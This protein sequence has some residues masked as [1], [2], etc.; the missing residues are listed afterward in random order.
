MAGPNNLSTDNG[1]TL[2]HLAL[3]ESTRD[4]TV[5][6]DTASQDQ[7][8][9]NAVAE[10]QPAP[11]T[12]PPRDWI[13]YLPPEIRQ[14]VFEYLLQLPYALPYHLP[15]LWRNRNIQARTGIFHTSRLIYRE[16][17]Y[18]FYSKNTFMVPQFPKVPTQQIGHMIQNI[19][20]DLT[21]SSETRA[22]RYRPREQF[23]ALMQ[24]FGD[25][26]IIRRTLN[27]LIYLSPQDDTLRPDTHLMPFFLRALGRFT[28]F[29]V[30]NLRL[31]YNNHNETTDLQSMMETQY[32]RVENALRLVLGPA[33]LPRA[34][35][36]DH[37]IFQPRDF[38]NAQQRS[39]RRNGD[40]MHHLD[41]IRLEWNRDR[42][43]R[44]AD[45]S[46]SPV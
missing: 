5:L 33:R 20:V 32:E 18:V 16:S 23:L 27:L 41:G 10:D 30:L 13:L 2:E 11:T 35:G 46:E 42:I 9:S 7:P 34:T 4:P 40:W 17:I 15:T 28:N 3:E 37:L 14:M 12:T 8:V 24:K 1:T 43:D 22:G 45:E 6:D 44:N 29:R 38:W 25:P 21:A 26:A 31:R 19:C 39:R 36:C